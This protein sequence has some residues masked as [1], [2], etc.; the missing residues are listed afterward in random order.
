VITFGSDANPARAEQMA[1]F[2]RHYDDQN[3]RVELLPGGSDRS[4]LPTTA[5]AGRAPYI[6]DIFA[7]SDVPLYAK[8]GIAL[9]LNDYL[10]ELRD[11]SEDPFNILTDTWQARLDSLRIDNPDW[12]GSDP[13]DE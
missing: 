4:S 13:I 8:K 6:V 9:P 1:I 2:D 3:L 7:E 10:K 11:R 5:A 12:D